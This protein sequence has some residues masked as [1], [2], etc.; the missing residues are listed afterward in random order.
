MKA[1]LLYTHTHT[2]THTCSFNEIKN[3]KEEYKIKSYL[4]IKSNGGI[5]LIALVI[6]IIILI[7]LAGISIMGITQTGIL[8][9]AKMAKIFFSNTKTKEENI[10]NNYDENIN[11]IIDGTRDSKENTPEWKF[12]KSTDGGKTIDISNLN[13][14]EL[15]IKA[16]HKVGG[17]VTMTIPKIAINESDGGSYNLRIKTKKHLD[18]CNINECFS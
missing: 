12:L 11:E 10:L 9:K 3:Y 5:T 17:S 7:I 16:Y 8:S 6:T 14:E 15:F 1:L 2:H 18:F 13:F 4:S